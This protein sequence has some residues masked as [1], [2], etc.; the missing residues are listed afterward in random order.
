MREC[1]ENYDR[2][3][4]KLCY[5]ESFLCKSEQRCIAHYFVCD[6]MLDCEDGSDEEGCSEC[7]SSVTLICPESQYNVHPNL[8][9]WSNMG[10]DSFC[11][12]LL[13]NK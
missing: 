11:A 3:G 5:D 2:S 12:C 10:K 13:K 7:L 9:L 1:D 6:G 8:Q 4:L